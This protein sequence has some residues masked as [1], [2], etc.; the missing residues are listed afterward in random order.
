MS[1]TVYNPHPHQTHT[2]HLKIIIIK[3]EDKKVNGI[4]KVKGKNFSEIV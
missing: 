3:G 2:P 4:L 1:I